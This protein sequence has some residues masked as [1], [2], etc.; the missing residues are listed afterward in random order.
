MTDT[1]PPTDEP[2]G[3][4]RAGM[5]TPDLKPE[6]QPGRA[7]LDGYLAQLTE[8]NLR[9]RLAESAADL[10]ASQRLRYR[11]F[12]E[13]MT[14]KPSPEMAADHRDFDAF[15]P[16][17]DHLLVCDTSLGEGA[18]GVVGTYRLFRGLQAKA[19]G[20]FYTVDEYDIAALLERENEVLEL[21]RSCVAPDYR[22]RH[23][24]ELLWRGIAAYVFHYDIG[25]MFGCASI[26]GTDVDEL[27]LPLSYL[28]HNHLA[29]EDRR[30]VAVP[31]RYVSMD[32][33]PADDLDRKKGLAALPPLIKGYLRLGGY[34]GDGAVVDPQFDTTDVC[35][36][37]ETQRVT[38]RYFKHYARRAGEG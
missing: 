10:L 2:A 19:F 6:T 8:G 31:E 24:M 4:P 3:T 20:R 12:Y 14:A 29:P 17:A 22:T 5:D 15:D 23:V 32:R 7:K 1:D 38:D 21:G 9:I 18:D 25:V 30:P 11:V 13:E 36:V 35:I 34:V 28:H 33:I 27:A 16:Q 26:P 37:V